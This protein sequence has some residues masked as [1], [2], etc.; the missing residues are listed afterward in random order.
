V[1]QIQDYKGEY[2]DR[3]PYN[4]TTNDTYEHI[5]QDYLIEQ[6]KATAGFADY[7]AEPID[8]H[9]RIHL[10]LIWFFKY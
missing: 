9:H 4:H 2:N 8:F 3:N 6:V 10:P 1:V 7:L 5:N